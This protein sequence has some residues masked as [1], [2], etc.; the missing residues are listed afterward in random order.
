MNS[1]TQ[2]IFITV[3][4]Q[5]MKWMIVKSKWLV[6]TFSLNNAYADMRQFP[7]EATW[8]LQI[9]IVENNFHPFCG[10]LQARFS[11]HGRIC[12]CAH[13]MGKIQ[14]LSQWP[15]TYLCEILNMPLQTQIG[16]MLLSSLWVVHSKRNANLVN[17]F[18]T[19]SHQLLT[20][21]NCSMSH[22][23]PQIG[24]EAEV[25]TWLI[26]MSI[27]TL[28]PGFF[29]QERKEADAGVWSSHS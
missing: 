17:N 27:H 4:S 10:N 23:Y 28:K 21:Q 29:Q 8:D 16:H 26:Q 6:L 18:L 3:F 24:K 1:N 12:P 20:D 14:A 9:K 7:P 13:R 19:A 11:Y 5:W 22:A 2:F 25:R 15:T